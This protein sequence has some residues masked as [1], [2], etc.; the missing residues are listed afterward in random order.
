M[1]RDG[2]RRFAV[3]IN[4]FG[5]INIDTQLVVGVEGEAISLTNGCIRCTIRGDLL[6]SALQLLDRPEPP[7]Y[8]IIEASG[9][10]DS[11]AVAETFELP[12]LRP[13]F[14]SQLQE[15][16]GRFQTRRL[17]GQPARFASGRVENPMLFHKNVALRA[18]FL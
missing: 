6:N 16:R 14:N 9:V 13:Y 18:T 11:W 1:L 4:D 7:E 12:K 17:P 15:L 5:S 3:L 10:S 8:L 2:G